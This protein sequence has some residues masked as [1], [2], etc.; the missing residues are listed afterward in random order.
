[1]WE[2]VGRP[3]IFYLEEAAQLVYDPPEVPLHVLEPEEL[4][5]RVVALVPTT[6]K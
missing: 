6:L 4:Q 3:K 1:M 2:I 5:V